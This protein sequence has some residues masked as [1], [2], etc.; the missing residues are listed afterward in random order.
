LIRSK[1]DTGI[2]VILDNRVKTKRYGK[3]FLSALPPCTVVVQT[4]R[5][6]GDDDQCQNNSMDYSQDFPPQDPLA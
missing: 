2:V 5:G 6:R 4:A 1:T 3:K